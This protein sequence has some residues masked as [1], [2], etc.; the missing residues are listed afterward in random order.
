MAIMYSVNLYDEL[1]KLL[2]N[3][4]NLSIISLGAVKA[5]PIIPWREG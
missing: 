5:L 2:T 3:D 1:Q 4:A